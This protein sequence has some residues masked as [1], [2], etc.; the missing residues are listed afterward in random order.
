MTF[1]QVLLILAIVA[2]ATLSSRFLPG[3]KSLAVKRML[4]LLFAAAAVVAILFPSLLTKIA[5]FFGVGRGADFLLYIFIVSFLLFAAAVIRAKARSDARV[6]SLARQVALLE[7]RLTRDDQQHRAP[8][9]S[10]DP[11]ATKDDSA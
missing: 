3:E 7:A 4:A 6:T 10:A 9:D 2:I 1:L 8:I 5:H 11:D